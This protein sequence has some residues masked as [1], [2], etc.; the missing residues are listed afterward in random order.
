MNTIMKEISIPLFF[1]NSYYDGSKY[2]GSLKCKGISKGANCQYFAYEL[3]RYFGLEI[4]DF[5]SSN[6]WED[7]ITTKKVKRL[8]PLD[9]VLFNKDTESYGAHVGVYLGNDKI[10]HLSKEVGYPTIWDVK[11]FKKR[12]KYKVFIGAKRIK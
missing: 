9:I 6:L 12:E 1:F 3:L 7:T 5:R 10:I 8:L 4:P 2:P 11:D